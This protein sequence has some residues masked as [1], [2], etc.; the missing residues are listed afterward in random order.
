MARHAE[1]ADRAR[2]IQRRMLTIRQD[3]DVDVQDVVAGARRL[4]DWRHYV[5][6]YPWVTLGA[7]AAV[8]YLLVPRR[9]E[10]VRPDA[11]TL[12]KLARADGLV[13]QHRPK[14]SAKAGIVESLATVAG[15]ILVRT[16]LAYAGQ[17]V[18]RFF[19]ERT[20]DVSQ[21]VSAS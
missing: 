11:E 14:Q 5:R 2:D 21:E 12:A 19:G 18:G 10:V 17:Q 1:H 20:A 3:L 16:A 7:A 4:T 6:D 8:G 15:R 13:V 9:L